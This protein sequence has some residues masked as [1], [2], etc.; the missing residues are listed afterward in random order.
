MLKKSILAVCAAVILGLAA[1]NLNLEFKSEVDANLSLASMFSVAKNE[2]GGG[3]KCEQK[4]KHTIYW[5]GETTEWWCVLGSDKICYLGKD[6]RWCTIPPDAPGYFCTL[7]SSEGGWAN[8][9]WPK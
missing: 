9:D 5:G 7:M 8:C 6:E 1:F 2:D 4:S 3:G